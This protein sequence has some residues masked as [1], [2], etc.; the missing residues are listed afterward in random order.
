MTGSEK[1]REFVYTWDDFNFL[2]KLSNQHSGI[3]VPDDKYDMFYSRLVKRVRMLGLR[4]FKSYCLYLQQ[5]PEREFT[6]FIN[7]VTTNLTSFFRE[8]HHFDYLRNTVV[9]ELLRRNAAQREIKLWSAGCST[10]EEPYSLA[11][12]LKD[13]VPAGWSIKILAT[14]LDTQVL[15]TAQEGVYAADRVA[16]LEPEQVRQWFQRGTGTQANKVRVKRELRELIH[17]RQ[18]NLMQDWPIRGVFD[19]I[20]CRNVLIYFDKETKTLLARRYAEHL[21]NDGHLFIGHSES[22][23]QLN[24]PFKLIGNTIYKK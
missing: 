5:H 22:L 6:D 19:A 17:F 8:S 7:S 3:L 9:P 2:R 20:F 12:T 1:S 24:V 4:D 23:H 21:I 15:A 14:D 10:G 16:S 11:I 18:L 13:A